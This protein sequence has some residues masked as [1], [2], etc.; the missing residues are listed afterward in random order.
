MKVAQVVCRELGCGAA[1]GIAGSGRFAAGSGSLWD[2]G[3]QC[4][5]TEPL[6]SA[7]ARRP[8]RSRGC[9]GAAGLICSR[10]CRGQR[11]GGSW[12]SLHNPPSYCPSCHSLHGL[13]AGEQQLGM[14]RAGGGGSEGDVGVGVR[15]RVGPARCP[16]PVP[17]PGLRPRPERAPGRLLRQRGGAAAAGRLGLQR[18]RAAPGPVPRGRAGE[19]AVCPRKRRGCHLLRCVG[20]LREELKGFWGP[21]R[22][23]DQKMQGCFVMT[24]C[25]WPFSRDCGVPAAGGG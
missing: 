10:K 7:C 9:S 16:R 12:G 22:N 5:G 18:E 3:F 20:H 11:G 24:G 23:L 17:P 1:L 13:P 8:P 21:P 2:G 6:L 4:N 19:A 14:Q 15:R 25:V